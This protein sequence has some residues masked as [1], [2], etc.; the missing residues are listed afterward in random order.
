M[1]E[2]D[3]RYGSFH[4]YPS[5]HDDTGKAVAD[6]RDNFEYLGQMSAYQ[7]LYSVGVLNDDRTLNKD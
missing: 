7:F 3:E 4:N 5:S 6:V 2:L 1:L